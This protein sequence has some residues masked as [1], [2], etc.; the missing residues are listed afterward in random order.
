MIDGIYFSVSSLST[1]GLNP[2]PL[3]SPPSY[4]VVVGL[5]S[6]TGIPVMGIAV[7]ELARL[8]I[9]GNAK[10]RIERDIKAKYV[11]TEIEMMKTL[12]I[13]NEMRKVNKYEFLLLTLAR[14]HIVD[15]FLINRIYK[16]FEELDVL[17]DNYLSY[18]ELLEEVFPQS[19]APIGNCTMDPVSSD[20]NPLHGTAI[21]TEDDEE[22]RRL[23]AR[24]SPLI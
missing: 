4:Y 12:G 19:A 11:K 9:E 5:Y 10:A 1:G 15:N 17:K 18:G 6:C 7:G 23:R 22:D 16:R 24:M 2:I 21:P 14:L 3:G 13:E 8:L 20:R